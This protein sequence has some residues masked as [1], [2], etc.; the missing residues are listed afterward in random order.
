MPFRKVPR[1]YWALGT[2]FLIVVFLLGSAPGPPARAQSAQSTFGVIAAITGSAPPNLIYVIQVSCIPSTTTAPPTSNPNGGTGVIGQR[3]SGL[4]M[5]RSGPLTQ[6]RFSQ[7]LRFTSSGSQ[8][9]VTPLNCDIIEY[10]ILG[11][12]DSSRLISVTKQVLSDRVQSVTWAWVG[13]TTTT[14]SP[15]V[16]PARIT[17]DPIDF[18]NSLIGQAQTRQSVIRNTGTVPVTVRNATATPPFSVGSVS[19]DLQPGASC[20]VDVSVVSNKTGEFAG[21]LT[22]SASGPNRQPAA[23][24]GALRASFD[25]RGDVLLTTPAFAPTIVGQSNSADATLTNVGSLAFNLKAVS[26][27]GPFVSLG[28]NCP[29]LIQPGKACAIQMVFRP[30]A[31]GPA[32]GTILVSLVGATLLDVRGSL[33]GVG[34]GAPKEALAFDPSSANLGNTPQG[35]P[36]AKVNVR[37][38]NTGSIP[39]TVASIGVPVTSGKGAKK[40]VKITPPSGPVT[41]TGA[42]V[43]K[44]LQPSEACNLVLTST[45]TAV[46]KR[47]LIIRAVS[48]TGTTAE[49]VVTGSVLRR[50]LTVSGPT[51]LG[52]LDRSVPK[53]AKVVIKNSGELPVTI[54]SVVVPGTAKTGISLTADPCSKTTLDVGAKCTVTISGLLTNQPTGAIKD[55]VVVS[56]GAGEKGQ[57]DVLAKSPS[58]AI[59]LLPKVA[60]FGKVILSAK[61]ERKISVRNIG[62]LPV[63]VKDAVI[64]GAG[65]GAFSLVPGSACAAAVV[66]VGGQCVVRVL[67]T[68]AAVGSFGATLTVNGTQGEKSAAALRF[69]VV[70]AAATTT[71]TVATTVPP[72][73]LPV[74]PKAVLRAPEIAPRGRPVS[75]VIEG[76]PANSV[77]QVGW[78]GTSLKPL[79]SGPD[80]KLAGSIMVQ[81]HDQLGVRS[82]IAILKPDCPP[83]IVSVLIVLDTAT[84]PRPIS[85]PVFR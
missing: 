4:Q 56:G 19:C 57:G 6:G 55:R 37:L 76:L 1:P 8:V 50:G 79:T 52:I 2:V 32:T 30:T 73:V 43:G 45:N 84:P 27:A 34:L 3:P 75:F 68:S 59:V 62:D 72:I 31:A 53:A 21:T 7:L 60:D 11:N 17:V 46:G 85:Q 64:T 78:E 9:I 29:V 16:V 66:P 41:L 65:A 58:R 54:A 70:A 81:E 13:P 44:T 69:S 20:S 71:A 48:A 28:N 40:T 38:V 14:T 82:L 39:L 74:C 10:Y 61:V 80:G 18:G 36:P 63:T 49:L 77:A 5:L 12:Y 15:P 26:V 35:S 25:D 42:C 67:G 22:V 33:S 24:Q 83:I 23:G 47:Q 51:Q